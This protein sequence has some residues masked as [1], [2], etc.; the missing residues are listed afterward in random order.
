M[1]IFKTKRFT[2]LEDAYVKIRY[3][4]WKRHEEND[5]QKVK[6]NHWSSSSRTLKDSVSTLQRPTS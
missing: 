6:N 1:Y 3:H 5:D 2:K 4:V